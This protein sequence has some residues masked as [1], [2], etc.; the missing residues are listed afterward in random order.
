MTL[1]KRELEKW[2]KETAAGA[3]APQA[4]RKSNAPAAEP[5]GGAQGL[6]RLAATMT[7]TL[8]RVNLEAAHAHLGALQ[9]TLRDVFEREGGFE[10]ILRSLLRL[11][12]EK[13][14]TDA[15]DEKLKILLAQ[16]PENFLTIL[17][18]TTFG[19]R[20]AP[21]ETRELLLKEV[22]RAVLEDGRLF[23]KE[24]LLAAFCRFY[25]SSAR[26]KA[27]AEAATVHWISFLSALTPDGKWARTPQ[28][29][30]LARQ[31]LSSLRILRPA[32]DTANMETLLHGL[33]AL[34]KTNL[35]YKEKL[36]AA[37]W[38]CLS[39][40]GGHSTEESELIRGVCILLSVPTPPFLA[41][42]AASV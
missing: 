19:L 14:P 29:T 32:D 37:L 13:A 26:P 38:T 7:G 3:R 39:G 16:K 17:Q 15:L 34:S 10:K 8:A 42:G 18:L 36:V 28:S 2:M 4:L 24:V 30:E 31:A 11:S 9:N 23:P 6:G 12:S 35:I 20:E 25:L 22:Q 27:N 21:N 1:I 33:M 5:L 41:K 40:D